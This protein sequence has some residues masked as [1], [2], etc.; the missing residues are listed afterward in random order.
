M[1]LIHGA[2][3]R[4]HEWPPPGLACVSLN[5]NALPIDNDDA[6]PAPRSSLYTH[7]HTRTAWPKPNPSLTPLRVPLP[8]CTRRSDCERG[9][10]MQTY[11]RDGGGTLL[12]YFYQY[13]KRHFFFFFGFSFACVRPSPFEISWV[14]VLDDLPPPVLRR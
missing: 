14:S 7:T 11:Y 10:Q 4:R 12:V 6:H 1:A 2:G 9:D 5:G 3:I 13:E 8:W